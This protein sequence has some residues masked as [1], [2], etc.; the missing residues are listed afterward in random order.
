M[1]DI[2]SGASA[3]NRFI[4]NMFTSWSEKLWFKALSVVLVFIIVIYILSTPFWFSYMNR[5]DTSEILDQT[6]S[7]HENDAREAHFKAYEFSQQTY[8]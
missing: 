1:A 6:I 8:R 3:F 5:R 2:K 4:D 7:Q